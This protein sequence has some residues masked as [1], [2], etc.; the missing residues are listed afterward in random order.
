MYNN[1]VFYLKNEIWKLDFVLKNG[2]KKFEEF[3]GSFF[4][5]FVM[6]FGWVFWLFFYVFEIC[7]VMDIIKFLFDI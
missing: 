6:Y 3:G 5:I 7:C 2:F 1:V 4:Y